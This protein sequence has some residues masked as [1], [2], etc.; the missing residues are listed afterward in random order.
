MTVYKLHVLMK[1]LGK[2]SFVYSSKVPTFIHLL[3]VD[4]C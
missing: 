3:E 1:T 2:M 4:W